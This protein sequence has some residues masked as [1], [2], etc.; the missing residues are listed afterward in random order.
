MLLL[1]LCLL[2]ISVMIS[3]MAMSNLA[4]LVCLGIIMKCTEGLFVYL[5]C[6]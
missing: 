2:F 1:L 4:R 5:M 6:T 3:L